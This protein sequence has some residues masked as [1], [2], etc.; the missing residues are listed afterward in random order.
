MLHAGRADSAAPSP[1]S[2]MRRRSGGGLGRKVP[3]SQPVK[4]QEPSMEEILASIRRI[5]SDDDVSKPNS[6]KPAPAPTAATAR[7]DATNRQN[8]IDATPGGFDAAEQQQPDDPAD[9]EV[10]ADVI[11]LAEAMQAPAFNGVDHAPQERPD[12][13]L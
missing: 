4:A 7:A 3:M 12:R 13:P 9:A 8:D 5:I 1:P 11:A 10:I 6:S 2:G